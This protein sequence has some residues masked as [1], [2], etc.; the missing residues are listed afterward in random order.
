MLIVWGS[1]K[2]L[3]LLKDKHLMK[4]VMFDIKDFYPSI[5]QDLLNKAIN[6][7]SEYMYIPKCDTEVSH[8]EIITV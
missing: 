7:V 8:K 3:N 6:F 4:F 2:W 1:F 5:T